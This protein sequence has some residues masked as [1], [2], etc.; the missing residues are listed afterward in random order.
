MAINYKV[1]SDI[2]T[3]LRKSTKEDAATF[4][5]LEDTKAQWG[6]ITGTLSTQTDLQSA[7]DAKASAS[8][9]STNTTNIATNASSIATK[10]DIL[11]FGIANTNAVKIDNTSAAANSGD[12]C[13]FAGNGIMPYTYAD[14]KYDL[15]VDLKAPIASP[16]FTGTT[17]A[18]KIVTNEIQC[19]GSL[20]SGADAQPI[21]YDAKVHRFRDFDASPT[22]LFVIEKIDGYTGARIGINKEPSASN[23]VALHVVAGK[24]NSTNVEDL[25]LKVIG[26]AHFD[27]YIRVG[28]YTDE[29]RNASFPTPT[30]G[31]IIYNQQHH[32][33]QGYVG[34][35][36]GWQKFNM[37][38]VSTS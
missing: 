16:S 31:T 30:N 6:Q 3:F 28:H 38:A 22:T 20:P 33:F 11:T 36:T 10:Q 23:A 32:E 21:N 35:G 34:G 25:A 12:I 26:G 18:P 15:G 27:D 13:K 37:G 9:V 1:S 4:L 14:L 29:T 7:L 19:E 8:D 2:D 5:G 17:T 24:N